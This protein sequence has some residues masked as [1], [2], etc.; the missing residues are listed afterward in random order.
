MSEK[1]LASDADDLAL[2]WEADWS[3]FEMSL[4][5]ITDGSAGLWENVIADLREGFMA[6][7][8]HRATRDTLA[9]TGCQVVEL[10]V[11]GARYGERG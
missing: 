6:V 2:Q 3:D 11:E 1:V 7:R 5:S 9:A 10:V 4:R 8:K